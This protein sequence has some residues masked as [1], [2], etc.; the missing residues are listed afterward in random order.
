MNELRCPFCGGKVHIVVCDDE[1][2]YPK[3]EGYENEPWSGLGYRICHS[4]EDAVGNC[5]I[6]GYQDED[7]MGTTIYDTAEEA[8][9]AWN[10]RA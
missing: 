3:P 8:T 9:I 5:P 7:V 2:N 4:K 6:A 1:G 10:K